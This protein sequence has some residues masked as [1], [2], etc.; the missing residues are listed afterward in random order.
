MF[1]VCIDAQKEP[2]CYPKILWFS[3]T[4]LILKNIMLEKLFYRKTNINIRTPGTDP[5]QSVGFRTLFYPMNIML[6]NF[7]E[8]SSKLKQ[9]KNVKSINNTTSPNLVSCRAIPKPATMKGW[10]KRCIL[11]NK[12]SWKSKMQ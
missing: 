8:D 2:S 6:K 11:K 7:I 4:Y 1:I 5:P 3:F 9:P 12:C 10:Q